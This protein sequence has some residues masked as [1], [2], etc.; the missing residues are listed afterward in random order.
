LEGRK[1]E[2]SNKRGG[3]EVI[4]AP[5][6]ESHGYAT[7]HGGLVNPGLRNGRFPLCYERRGGRNWGRMGRGCVGRSSA[8]GWT[9]A[10]HLGSPTAG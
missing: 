9:K 8:G 10:D 2:E 5:V 4:V 3:E 6:D 1:R 7:K